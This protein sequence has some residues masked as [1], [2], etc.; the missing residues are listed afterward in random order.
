MATMP[1]PYSPRDARRQARNL[2]RLQRAQYKAQYAYLARRPSFVGPLVLI[3][4]GV[5][6][7]LLE[8]GRLRASTFWPWYA[9]WW[10]VVLI[11]IGLGLLGEYF[12]DRNNAQP[13]RRS[14]GGIVWLIVLFSVLGGGSHLATGLAPWSSHWNDVFD[15]P[16]NWPA[17]FGEQH[18]E[19]HTLIRP[20]AAAGTLTIENAR[21]EVVVSTAADAG[22]SE[23]RVEARQVAHAGSDEAARRILDATRAEWS[24]PG[25]DLRLSTPGREGASVDLKVTVPAGIALVVH[26][27]HGDVEVSGVRRSVE[28]S[29]AHGDVTLDNLGAGAHVQMDHG[30]LKAHAIAGDLAID[31]RANDVSVSEVQGRSLLNG[32][33]FGDIRLE[34]IGAEVHFHSS[35][36]SLDAPKLGGELTFDSDGLR[37]GSPS[38]GLHLITRE[39][40]IEV[41]DLVGDAHIEDSNADVTVSTGMPLG[42]LEV[43]N[44]TGAIAVT[45]PANASFS[46]HGVAGHDE[47][48]TTDFALATGDNNGRKTLSGQVGQGGPHLELLT[49]HGDLTLRRGTA[50]ASQAEAPERPERPEKP[51]RHLH[52]R[53]GEPQTSVQ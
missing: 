50:R 53:S 22:P 48:V 30:D 2:N 38:G 28:V 46:V 10:P 32:D 6:A 33:F 7:L 8:T 40:N 17:L 45:V 29:D 52:A 23:V 15:D 25:G 31:G 21:G 3:A 41:T 14:V 44:H 36:T 13:G 20:I 24:G 47:D 5:I 27:T 9:R 12:L 42:N 37:L 18:T 39:K 35:R 51:E 43:N 11:L 19:V 1:P 4:V 16:G 34:G 26:T 49:D